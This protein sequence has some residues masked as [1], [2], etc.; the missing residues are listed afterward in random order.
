MYLNK[1]TNNCETLADKEFEFYLCLIYVVLALTFYFMTVWY[2][3]D[4]ITSF[5]KEYENN[6]ETKPIEI[7]A[8]QKITDDNQ[9]DSAIEK[10][11]EKIDVN[12]NRMEKN[13]M[14]QLAVLMSQMQE[15]Q[16]MQKNKID[17]Q[18]DESYDECE[19]RGE[20]TSYDKFGRAQ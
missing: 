9:M 7:I 2:T 12:M 10:R 20:Y 17:E 8:S 1:D 3:I 11:F 6:T 19:D 16:E 14:T 5:V 15:L 4:F 18:R 13:I